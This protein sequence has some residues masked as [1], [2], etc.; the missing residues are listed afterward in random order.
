MVGVVAVIASSLPLFPPLPLSSGLSLCH[1]SA[2]QPPV[3]AH[4][5]VPGA[6]VLIAVPMVTLRTCWNRSDGSQCIVCLLMEMGSKPSSCGHRCWILLSPTLC[7]GPIL[8]QQ[9]WIW[10]S[11]AGVSDLCPPASSSSSLWAVSGGGRVPRTVC[12]LEA[13]LLHLELRFVLTAPC[14]P[15]W[16][17]GLSET[18]VQQAPRIACMGCTAPPPCPQPGSFLPTQP[19]QQAGL[20]SPLAGA[21][22]GAAL[23]ERLRAATSPFL[24][25]RC[26]L[27]RG[28]SPGEPCPN[29]DPA[30]HLCPNARPVP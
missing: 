4:P 19:Q 12:L 28:P 13:A 18:G 29:W 17:R 22:D 25:P 8:G 21:Q 24:P 7:S 6:S 16:A 3:S 1:G 30:G 14:L 15:A 11:C 5:A 23:S 26:C 10:S 2:A 27:C 20:C 9:C